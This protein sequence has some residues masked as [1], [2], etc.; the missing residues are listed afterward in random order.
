MQQCGAEKVGKGRGG[1]GVE[2]YVVSYSWHECLDEG[3]QCQGRGL[4]CGDKRMTTG[5]GRYQS[6]DERCTFLLGGEVV[7]QPLLASDGLHDA[8]IRQLVHGLPGRGGFQPATGF[9]VR[10]AR[11]ISVENSL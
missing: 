3:G 1:G 10:A 8:C 2:R 11:H 5:K 6:W 7:P 4:K 9:L